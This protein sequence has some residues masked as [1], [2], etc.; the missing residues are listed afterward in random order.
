MDELRI[1]YDDKADFPSYAIV[2]SVTETTDGTFIMQ[3]DSTRLQL[4]PFHGGIAIIGP[5]L[6]D[7]AHHF[8][9]IKQ[10]NA[11]F[12]I[13]LVTAS[14]LKAIGRHELAHLDVSLEKLNMLGLVTRRDVRFLVVI[15][16]HAD[17]WRQSLGLEKKHYHMTTSDKDDHGIVKG[18][19]A[20][21]A[22]T[23]RDTIL[24]KVIVL[25]EDAMDHL[26]TSCWNNISSVRT[27]PLA[28]NELAK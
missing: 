22:T 21:L 8:G 11:P 12:L 19:E 6:Y 7:A 26:V 2:G 27:L 20:L 25:G 5:A 24:N 18:I 23:D 10:P 3:V 13:T 4:A 16:N 9:I 1:K 17:K 14:E 15:W 28:L